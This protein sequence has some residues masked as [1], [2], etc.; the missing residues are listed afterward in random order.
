MS[1]SSL[2][3]AC[4]NVN[5]IRSRL[6]AVCD[7]L[8]EHKPDVALL[9]ET[10][11]ADVAFPRGALED[12]G[13]NLAIHGEKSY[14]GVAILSRF[15]LEDVEKTLPGDDS[16]TQA[17]YIEALVSA[18][19]GL[20]RVA[21]V[22]VPNGQAV[23]SEKF[24]Y[25]LRFFERLADRLAALREEELPAIIGGDYN[26]APGPLDLYDPK[27]LDGTICY[28]PQERAG[29][30]RLLHLG[31]T[32]AWRTCHPEAQ[33]FSFWDYRGSSFSAGKG[34][35]IDHLLLSPQAADRLEA[36]E[37]DEKPRSLPRAS[38]HAPVWCRLRGES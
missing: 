11:A 3:F 31:Y 32:E 8:R 21:S 24:P 15:P 5:S 10:K 20:V 26:V 28:H 19:G 34:Y 6:D 29:F 38:D 33:Q 25:K 23:D 2:T 36:C 37:I 14:N 22:Y 12:L 35:R 30:R 18:P 7:W 1:A 27:R 16:D 9:Q 17:R 13:Y 4:W